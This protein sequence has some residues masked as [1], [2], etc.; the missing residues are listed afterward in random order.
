VPDE[1]NLFEVPPTNA[2]IVS[3]YWDEVPPVS[4]LDDGAP[5]EFAITGTGDYIDPSQCALQVSVKVQNASGRDL[6]NRSRVQPCNNM[7]HT[8]FSQVECCVNNTYISSGSSVNYGYKSLLESLFSF[9]GEAKKT[10]LSLSLFFKDTAGHMDDAPGDNCENKGGKKRGEYIAGSKEVTLIGRPHLDIF[11]QNKLLLP[12]LSIRLKFNRADPR[13][14]LIA[15]DTVAGGGEAASP[16]DFKLIIT[17]ASFL[18]RRVKVSETI[19][20]A[21]LKALSTAN[22]LYPINHVEVKTFN[23]PHQSMHITE[24]LLRSTLPKRIILGLVST[25][26]YNG[27]YNTNPYHFRSANVSYVD[28][29]V[30]GQRLTAKPL[31][32]DFGNDNFCKEYA[33]LFFGMGTMNTNETFDIKRDD[34][35]GGYALYCYNLH[36]EL[37]PAN[38][39]DMVQ[40]G[41]LRVEMKFSQPLAE[42]YTCILYYE[43]DQ[44]IE[45]TRDKTIIYDKSQ[46]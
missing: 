10:Q 44:V 23:I 12:D 1:L 39:V 3:G 38:Y 8:L 5:I 20:L 41:S 16:P 37:N 14:A 6:T 24:E 34:F 28:M 17:K 42:P 26:S 27:S 4:S 19:K 40:Q 33:N 25:R 35:G 15:G 46:I 29:Y 36:P 32:P 9:T 21:H 22:A 43:F 13:F 2:S 31:T 30:G 7:L 11:H 45:V 18:V